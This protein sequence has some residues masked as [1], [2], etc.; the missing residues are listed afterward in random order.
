MSRGRRISIIGGLVA[1]LGSLV[2]GAAESPELEHLFTVLI[3]VVI[4]VI[5][6]LVASLGGGTS[7]LSSQRARA[8]LST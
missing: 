1:F 8:P 6:G 4:C 7:E 2:V 5:G 3:G